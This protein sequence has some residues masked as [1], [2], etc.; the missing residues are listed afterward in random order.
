MG[1]HFKKKGNK[2]FETVA[3]FNCLGTTV[4]NRNFITDKLRADKVQVMFLPILLSNL[5]LQFSYP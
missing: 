1:I 3:E 4:T 2:S 5:C